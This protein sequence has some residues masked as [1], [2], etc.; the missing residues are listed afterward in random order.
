MQGG[1]YRNALQ[2]ASVKDHDKIIKLLLS[3]DADV[4]ELLLSN[5]A[6]VNAQGR[7]Y[8]SELY[9]WFGGAFSREYSSALYEASV[10][11][12]DKVV[13]LLLSK[14]ADVNVLYDALFRG[15]N[16]IVDLPLSNISHPGNRN[17]PGVSSFR[18]NVTLRA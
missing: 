17:Y 13:E 1:K 14:G 4:V 9:G 18:F 11:S 12:H 8:S 16:K 15:H 10:R 7:K 5:G 6:D 3:N 2:A